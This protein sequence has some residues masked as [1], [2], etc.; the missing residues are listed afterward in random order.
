MKT[1][2]ENWILGL[3]LD[4]KIHLLKEAR[5]D[6]FP[7]FLELSKLFCSVS[8]NDGGIESEILDDI[9]KEYIKTQEKK[10]N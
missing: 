2:E 9:D 3:P 5:K 4:T 8:I 10:E 1:E 7:V 6:N